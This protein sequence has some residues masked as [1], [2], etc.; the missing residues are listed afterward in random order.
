V[1]PFSLFRCRFCGAEG[2]V[3][4]VVLHYPGCEILGRTVHDS[5]VPHAEL[6]PP[7]SD[8]LAALKA[9][10]ERHEWGPE[11]I[12]QCQCKPHHDARILIAKSERKAG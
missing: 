9:L 2:S 4:E 7:Y 3:P 12:G 5:E 1:I 6:L 10:S 11:G 8:L